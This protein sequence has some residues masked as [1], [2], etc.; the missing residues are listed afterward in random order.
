MR[1]LQLVPLDL[2]LANEVVAQI[3]RHHGPVTGHKFS[4]GVV[5]AAG[6]L[7]GVAIVGRPNSRALDNGWTLE[8]SRVATD[9]HRNACSMLYG[10]CCRAA[11]ALGYRK[12]VTYKLK[13]ETGVSMVAAGFVVVGEVKGRDW[14]CASRPRKRKTPLLDKERLESTA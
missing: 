7:R 4:I 10:A 6:E 8:I 14:S 11:F 2:D 9:G 12:V 3:H 1:S 13:S 5:D